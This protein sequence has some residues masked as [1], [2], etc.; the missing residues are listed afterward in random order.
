LGLFSFALSVFALSASML[1]P[2]LA[3]AETSAN[4]QYEEAISGPYG[5]N[6]P[7]H[8]EPSAHSSNDGGNTSPTSKSPTS[9]EKG[10]SGGSPYSKTEGTGGSGGTGQSSPEGGSKGG[11]APPVNH[12]GQAQPAAQNAP[13]SDGGGSSPLVPIL[14]AIAALAAISI[15]AVMLRAR[16]Q[17]AG[18]GTPVS[19]GAS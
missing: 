6:K 11:E 4:V 18:S 5:G 3:Q 16:R 7:V 13:H 2:A 15:G 10:S 12:S 8:K 1:F 14:I 19:P 9:S 17:R